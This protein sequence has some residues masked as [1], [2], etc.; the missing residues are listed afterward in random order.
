MGIA[1]RRWVQAGLIAAAIAPFLVACVVERDDRYDRYPVET[2]DGTDVPG[3][4]AT[5]SATATTSPSATTSA[6]GSGSGSGS[7][8][9]DGGAAPNG[10]TAVVDTNRSLSA[11][12][13]QGVGVFVEYDSGGHWDITWTCDTALSGETCDFSL[14]FTVVGGGVPTNVQPYGNP[15]VVTL[16]NGLVVD[17]TIG[18]SL[19]ELTFDT[20]AGATM[21]MTTKLSGENNGAIVFFVQDGKVN[22]GYSGTLSDPLDFVGSAP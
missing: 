4:A 2:S 1:D 8:A 16:E 14:A 18:D 22:G 6:T 12:A 5:G 9:I 11:T 19:D 13:G 3:P 20:P 17:S 10:V 7:A 15:K 21:E